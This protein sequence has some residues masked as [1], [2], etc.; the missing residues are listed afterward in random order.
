MHSEESQ[1]PV[2][3]VVIWT[4]FASTQQQQWIWQKQQRC[5]TEDFQLWFLGFLLVPFRN[6]LQTFLHVLIRLVTL[7]NN[8]TISG[9]KELQV[10]SNAAK[11]WHMDST[12]MGNLAKDLC[13]RRQFGAAE[14]LHNQH[15]LYETVRSCVWILQ[16]WRK[17]KMFFFDGSVF[18]WACAL[19]LVGWRC[20][21]RVSVCVC[22]VGVSS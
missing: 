4:Y 19:W 14:D 13:G 17:D 5:W 10:D 12:H 8:I 21:R 20:E 15:S 16:L 7:C 11:I 3:P 22:V 2:R 6:H 18:C 1:T 9:S